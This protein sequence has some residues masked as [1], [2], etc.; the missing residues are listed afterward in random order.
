VPASPNSA[1]R[2][3]DERLDIDTRSLINSC[4]AAAEELQKTRRLADALEKENRLLAER[5]ETAGR[6]IALL[7]ELNETRKSE[8]ESLRTAL[9][10][11]NEAIAAKD[12]VIAAQNELVQALKNRKT[13]PWKRLGDVLLGIGIIAVL[14]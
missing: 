12:T 4:A 10:A 13:S 1:T 2:A 8:A 5:L 11:K 14:K 3:A 6:S 9:A 7:K